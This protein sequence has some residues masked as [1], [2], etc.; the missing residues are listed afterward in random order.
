MRKRDA[1]RC[2]RAAAIVVGVFGFAAAMASGGLASGGSPAATFDRTLSCP[3]PVRGGVNLL[4]LFA[5]LKGSPPLVDRY[6]HTTPY[7]TTVEVDA[8]RKP[9]VVQGVVHVVQTTYAGASPVFK[10]G[11]TFDQTL[12]HPT[13]RIP[14]ARAGLPAAGVFKGTHG[15]GLHREC[16]LAPVVAV[17]M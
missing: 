13:R 9:L 2:G 14:L 4:D 5:R 11:Y 7:P 15:G 10:G 8:G 3:V 12:C 6:G 16:W 1:G 17:R